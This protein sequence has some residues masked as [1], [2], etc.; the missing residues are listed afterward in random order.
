MATLVHPQSVAERTRGFA[1]ACQ[2]DK[3]LD[4]EVDYMAVQPRRGPRGQ[5]AR[6]GLASRRC[7]VRPPRS[8]APGIPFGR[9]RIVRARSSPEDDVANPAVADAVEALRRR[10]SRPTSSSPR[11]RS[12]ATS[13]MCSSSAALDG[14]KRATRPC[15]G[16]TSPMHGPAAEP[17]RSPSARPLRR[18]AAAARRDGSIAAAVASKVRPP[19]SAYASQIGFQFGGPHG[20]E[21]R[22][23]AARLDGDIP[24]QARLFARGDF[25]PLAVLNTVPGG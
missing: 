15:G 13:T 19:A 3:G 2:L 10:P 1:L 9:G 21:A 7:H 11:R 5:R 22:L 6:S 16:T 18:S 4:S 25:A 20:L 8:P 12:A 14:L 24:G 23:I 17:L